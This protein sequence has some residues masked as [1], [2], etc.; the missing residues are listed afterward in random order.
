MIACLQFLGIKIKK[1][2]GTKKKLVIKSSKKKQ[3][4]DRKKQ[5]KHTQNTLIWR[6]HTNKHKY[7]CFF[8]S[9]FFFSPFSL[10]L[11]LPF[12]PSISPFNH[13]IQTHIINPPL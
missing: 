5:N 8:L 1:N 6:T 9:S 7:T 10:N 2:K 12:I 11:L 4:K 13:T 3:Q